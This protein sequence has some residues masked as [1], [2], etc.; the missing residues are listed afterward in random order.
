MY[1]LKGLNNAFRLALGDTR[2]RVQQIESGGV[3]LRGRVVALEGRAG[4]LQARLLADEQ[5]IQ[6]NLA[7]MQATLAAVVAELDKLDPGWR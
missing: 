6:A 1:T 7:S 2:Q 4:Q 5:N 3:D